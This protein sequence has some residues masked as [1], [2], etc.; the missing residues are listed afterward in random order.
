M[1][2]VLDLQARSVE[3]SSSGEAISSTLSITNCCATQAG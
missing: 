1:D 3:A 2:F